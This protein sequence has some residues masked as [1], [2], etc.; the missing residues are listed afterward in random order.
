MCKV[1]MCKTLN[2]SNTASVKLIVNPSNSEFTQKKYRRT[3]TYV[4]IFHP[5]K[6]DL[7]TNTPHKSVSPENSTPKQVTSR[8]TT[9]AKQQPQTSNSLSVSR[10]LAVERRVCYL[11]LLC[12]PQQTH[13][14]PISR[15]LEFTRSSESCAVVKFKWCIC[16]SYGTAESTSVEGY[17][18]AQME[19]YKCQCERQ[20]PY[21][22]KKVTVNTFVR[23]WSSNGVFAVL[24][25]RRKRLV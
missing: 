5:P 14:T 23:L 25:D 22:K 10:E 2:T 17:T 9:P 13:N 12:H 15:C 19:W 21:V 8:P 7:H 1:S 4:L 18:S 6:F 24:V 20:Y 16:G 11:L 3:F